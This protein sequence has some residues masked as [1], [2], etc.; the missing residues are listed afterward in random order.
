MIQLKKVAL[1][2]LLVPVFLLFTGC[3]S[4]FITRDDFLARMDS[5]EKKIDS[6]AVGQR[7][8][9][10]LEDAVQELAFRINFVQAIEPTYAGYEELEALRAE[11]QIIKNMLAE[12]VIDSASSAA[13]VKTL[14]DKIDGVLT[15]S[16]ENDIITREIDDLN[17]KVQALESL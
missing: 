4:P 7:K 8:I 16:V 9:V 5:I 1:L 14:Y 3:N 13:I 10:Q 6:L 12:S 11:L 17:R 2:F 15:G